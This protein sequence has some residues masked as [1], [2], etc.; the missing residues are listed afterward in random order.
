MKQK[1][2]ENL[3]FYI[4]TAWEASGLQWTDDN[5]REVEAIVDAILEEIPTPCKN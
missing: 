2:V 1:A 3:Q 4:K 5:D